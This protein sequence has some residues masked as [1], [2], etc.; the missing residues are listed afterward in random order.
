MYYNSPNKIGRTYINSIL[1][2]TDSSTTYVF[3][4]VHYL[5]GKNKVCINTSYPPSGTLSYRVLTTEPVGNNSYI[6]KILVSGTIT[7]LPH[8]CNNSCVCPV[9]E[10]VYVVISIPSATSSAINIT[11]GNVLVE[12]FSQQECALVTNEVSIKSSFAVATT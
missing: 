9:T 11:P 10:G 7:Y 1:P 6:V 4:L 5:C 12:P 8:I 3:D 2:I